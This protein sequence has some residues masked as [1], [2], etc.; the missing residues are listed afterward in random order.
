MV[1][2][3]KLVLSEPGTLKAMK[4]FPIIQRHPSG[5]RHEQ[6]DGLLIAG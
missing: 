3:K 4:K 5:R 1:L 2:E 6:C